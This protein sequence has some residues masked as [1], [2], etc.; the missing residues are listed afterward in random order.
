MMYGLKENSYCLVLS[1]AL[2]GD[3]KMLVNSGEPN[4]PSF[5]PLLGNLTASREMWVLL[6]TW[7]VYSTIF[8]LSLLFILGARKE[9]RKE[10]ACGCLMDWVLL[11][12]G[13][14]PFLIQS[15]P[16]PFTCQST[17]CSDIY[18]ESQARCRDVR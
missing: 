11:F 6:R 9:R 4:M 17:G 7:S 18:G 10:R 16:I 13:H 1:S 2:R 15:R 12:L 3:G 14:R 5:A 8:W